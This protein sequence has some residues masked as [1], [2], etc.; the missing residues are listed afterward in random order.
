[1]NIK[2]NTWYIADD[3]ID[4]EEGVFY[5]YFFE[6]KPMRYITIDADSF[7]AQIIK[8]SVQEFQDN[9]LDVFDLTEYSVIGLQHDFVKG[10]FD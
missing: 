1:M 2:T 9:I 5:S 10:V 7:N 4:S 3:F 6:V 8:E